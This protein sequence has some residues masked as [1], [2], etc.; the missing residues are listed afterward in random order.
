MA[1]C[2]HTHK[3]TTTGK[4]IGPTSGLL[5]HRWIITMRIYA[6]FV[7]GILLNQPVCSRS[8]TE[9]A[10]WVFGNEWVCPFPKRKTT[11]DID[12]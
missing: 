4:V 11:P 7:A 1:G 8:Q 10:T 9:N 2:S 6:V 12:R 3:S 5:G